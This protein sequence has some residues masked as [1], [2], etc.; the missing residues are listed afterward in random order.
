MITLLGCRP[1]SLPSPPPPFTHLHTILPRVQGSGG[2]DASGQ[3]VVPLGQGGG[4]AVGV[5]FFFL[6]RFSFFSVLLFVLA[7]PNVPGGWRSMKRGVFPED[8]WLGA[9]RSLKFAPA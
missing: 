8:R 7:D 1:P 6:F 2:L 3:S 9:V 5:S 4:L